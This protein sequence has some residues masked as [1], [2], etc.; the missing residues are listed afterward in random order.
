MLCTSGMM[1]LTITAAMITGESGHDN[2]YKC[3]SITNNSLKT[4]I[5][6]N[7]MWLLVLVFVNWSVF[8]IRFI[9]IEMGQFCTKYVT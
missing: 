2:P 9:C 3:V 1:M 8:V 4:L 7:C 5:Q 6:S